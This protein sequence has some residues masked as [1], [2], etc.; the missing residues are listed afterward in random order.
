MAKPKCSKDNCDKPNHAKTFC[1]NHYMAHYRS[2]QPDQTI[3]KTIAAIRRR[4]RKRIIRQIEKL[5]IHLIRWEIIN[6]LE[7]K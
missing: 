2:Q 4:E 6:Y 3:Q 7:R 5:P 1:L